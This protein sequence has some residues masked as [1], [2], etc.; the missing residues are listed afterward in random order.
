MVEG[1]TDLLRS[2]LRTQTRISEQRSFSTWAGISGLLA[3]VA[4]IATIGLANLSSVTA[5]DGP[6]GM[7]AYLESVDGAAWSIYAYGIAGIILCIAY[8]PLAIGAYRLLGRSTGAWY[9]T[10]SILVGLAVLLPAYVLNMLAP[11]GLSDVVDVTG[12]AGATPLYVTYAAAISLGELFFTVGSLLTLC[13]GPLLWGL[14]WLR[15]LEVFRWV[16][17]LGILTAITGAV[18]FVWLVDSPVIAITLMV[19]VL[20]SLGMFIGVSIA[21]L[22]GSRDA[23][24]A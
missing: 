1:M 13:I 12:A 9:G 17:W 4:F 19:N 20:L 24:R 7:L 8:V 23:A 11:A 5:P 15:S 2:G 14:M 21:L 16:G 6:E 3:T 18:W 22:A 10:A